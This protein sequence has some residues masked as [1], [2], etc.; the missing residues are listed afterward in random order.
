MLPVLR[1]DWVAMVTHHEGID[2]T[3][4]PE[5]DIQA[6]NPLSS[7]IDKLSVSKLLTITEY[8]GYP[9]LE[10]STASTFYRLW[11]NFR[12]NSSVLSGGLLLALLAMSFK[13]ELSHRCTKEEIFLL[14]KLPACDYHNEYENLL[15]DSIQ[16]TANAAQTY[17]QEDNLMAV[18]QTPA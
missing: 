1:E 18:K 10:S 13:S 7:S 3:C 5:I 17:F 2:N 16:E 6:N 15:P 8:I 4:R 9:R 14:Q 11:N 12:F